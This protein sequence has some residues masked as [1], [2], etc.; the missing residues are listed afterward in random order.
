MHQ[1]GDALAD[2]PERKAAAMRPPSGRCR[3]RRFG[4]T[5]G[6]LPDALPCFTWNY[7]VVLDAVLVTLLLVWGAALTNHTMR[8]V[9]S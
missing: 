9:Q 5:S 1:Q 3:Y 2:R 4:T 8:S 6:A 7:L